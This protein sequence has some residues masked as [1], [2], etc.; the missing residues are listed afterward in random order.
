MKYE[1]VEV[2]HLNGDVQVQAISTR[3]LRAIRAKSIKNGRV[4]FVEL[5][6]WKLV[7]GMK[8]PSF[9]PAEAREIISRYTL[10]V[11]QPILDRIDQLSGT[12]EHLRARAHA[13]RQVPRA[14]RFVVETTHMAN[15]WLD[16]FPDVPSAPR[17]RESHGPKPLRRR[18]SRRGDRSAASSSDDPDPDPEPA[19]RRLCENQQC[20]TDISHLHTLRRYCND[21]CQQQALRDRRTLELL[22]EL[23]GTVAEG[24]ACVCEPRPGDQHK[25]NV[26]ELGHCLKCGYSRT[27]VMREWVLGPG[28][29]A[30]RPLAARTRKDTWRV[31]PDRAL[32]EQLKKTKKTRRARRVVAA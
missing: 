23:V 16:R 2:P 15:A 7:Y 25:H 21:A 6:L 24:L 28:R 17:S 30:S 22:D 4:D 27:K 29:R 11:L 20:E 9:T 12:D 31:S 8:D 10:R 1:T 5:M 13:Q 19:E 3:R 14:G 18:G 32:R 26:V